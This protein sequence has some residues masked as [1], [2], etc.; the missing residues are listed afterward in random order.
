MQ[1]SHQ[2]TIIC[3]GHYSAHRLGQVL[4]N[5]GCIQQPSPLNHFPGRETLREAP[6][7]LGTWFRSARS[8]KPGSQWWSGTMKLLGSLKNRGI[9]PWKDVKRGSIGMGDVPRCTKISVWLV[10]LSFLRPQWVMGGSPPKGYRSWRMQGRAAQSCCWF[11]KR[12]DLTRIIWEKWM[13]FGFHIC[14]NHTNLYDLTHSHLVEHESDVAE[15][16]P[17]P[18][19]GLQ[20]DILIQ[21]C[22]SEL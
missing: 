16:W 5:Q 3:N 22:C 13:I 2:I 6:N 7:F 19:H 1:I 4:L 11:G 8:S 14:R 10:V 21:R 9:Y 15:A 12:S 20:V 18:E 17:E